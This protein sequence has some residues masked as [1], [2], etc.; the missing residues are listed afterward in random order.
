MGTPESTFVVATVITLILTALVA[1]STFLARI[2]K[3][4]GE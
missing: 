4:K 3:V 1:G 2:G